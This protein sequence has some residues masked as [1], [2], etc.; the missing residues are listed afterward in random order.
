MTEVTMRVARLIVWSSPVLLTLV[1]LSAFQINGC[2]GQDSAKG[3]HRLENET[4]KCSTNIIVVP[5]PNGNGVD[6]KA[7]YVCDG[8]TLEWDNRNSATFKVH[9]TDGCPFQSCADIT[10]SS[11][12]TV[13]P[14]PAELT[15]YHYIITVNGKDHD[16][17]VVG[18][19][20]N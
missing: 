9:F 4:V 12:R 10:D 14:Q 8:G 15:V 5:D 1:F 19:G 13:A 20:H 2:G 16:P 7:V 17:H 3:G 6:H 18:G 11:P